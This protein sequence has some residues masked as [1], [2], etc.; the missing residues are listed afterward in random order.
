MNGPFQWNRSRQED[1]LLEAD[2]RGHVLQLYV[3]DAQIRSTGLWLGKR[4]PE[5]KDEG[6]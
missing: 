6:K 1:L 3:T 2:V 4:V 5:A